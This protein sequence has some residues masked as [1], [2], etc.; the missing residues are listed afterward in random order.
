[1]KSLVKSCSQ[2]YETL[3]EASLNC[4]VYLQADVEDNKNQEKLVDSRER[5][6]T[7]VY[8]GDSKPLNHLF[9]TGESSNTVRA[10]VPRPA[11][12]YTTS[13][14]YAN[15]GLLLCMESM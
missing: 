12:P 15:R 8:V 4:K 13:C 1:M 7:E 10:W 6:D 3:S 2:Q 9:S 5:T 14:K 11:Q